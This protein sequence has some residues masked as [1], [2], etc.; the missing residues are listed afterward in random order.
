MTQF[1]ACNLSMVADLCQMAMA[2]GYFA[3]GRQDDWATFEVFSARDA[4]GLR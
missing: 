1:D 2:N 4:C 3:D